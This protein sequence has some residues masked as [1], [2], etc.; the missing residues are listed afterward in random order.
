MRLGLTGITSLSLLRIVCNKNIYV[1]LSVRRYYVHKFCTVMDNNRKLWLV[2]TTLSILLLT[3]LA[4][5][6]A[7]TPDRTFPQ[8]CNAYVQLLFDTHSQE[9]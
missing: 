2:I 9:R 7:T 6:K 5:S 8:M 3:Q 1:I 4:H